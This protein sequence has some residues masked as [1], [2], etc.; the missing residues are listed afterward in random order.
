MTAQQFTSWA[1]ATF[2]KYLPAMKMEV[3][4]WLREKSPYF[5]AALREVALREHPS[6]YGRPP[7]V[8]ELEQ[9][10]IKAYER[11][12]NLEAI[13]ASRNP[14]P[15]IGEVVESVSEEEA[16]EVA[17]KFREL[18]EGRMSSDEQDI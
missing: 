10:K 14:R 11:G 7:G 3:E 8:Y 5:T 9:F 2:G 18:M 15:Q 17:K 13:A 4:N 16:A 12:H 1:E 6:V